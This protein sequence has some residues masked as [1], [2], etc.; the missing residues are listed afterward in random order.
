MKSRSATSLLK[1]KTE[2]MTDRGRAKG[3]EEKKKRE[4]FVDDLSGFLTLRERCCKWIK[5]GSSQCMHYI[6]YTYNEFGVGDLSTPVKE[7]LLVY[8]RQQK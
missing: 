1:W 2:R 5:A 3:G 4:T 8:R 7:K 6:F